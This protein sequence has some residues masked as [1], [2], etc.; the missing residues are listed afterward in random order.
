LQRPRT[1]SN[2][3]VEKSM[4]LIKRGP[5]WRYHLVMTNIISH[6]KSQA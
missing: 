1:A 6:G 2:L 4:F 5:F 3:M